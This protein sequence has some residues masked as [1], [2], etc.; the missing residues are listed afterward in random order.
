MIKNI[1]FDLD[2]T[3]LDFK[4]CEH[5]AFCDMLRHFGAK[6][7]DYEA[8]SQRYSEINVEQW[9]LLELGKITRKEVSVNRFKYLFEEAGLDIDAE[10]AAE[11]YENEL[12]FNHYYIEGAEEI[13]KRLSK[14]Y[15]LYIATN[16]HSAVQ[17][18]R[19]SDAGL[20]K[21]IKGL[22]ISEEIGYDKPSR[23]Y[24]DRC[25]SMIPD[26][27]REE[28]V[29]VGDSL[30]SD[31]LGGNNA[32]IVAIWYSPQVREAVGAKPDYVLRD[33]NDIDGLLEKI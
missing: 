29:I 1:L 28:T 26:F 3:I 23:E 33:L 6:N 18:R 32:G 14:K 19:V 16:G 12:S 25:F 17:H 2:G 15:R 31:I 22:F 9:K 13:V 4:K 5:D 10:P 24:F 7:V 20:E 27:S 11:Y 8:L 30:S 21:Y